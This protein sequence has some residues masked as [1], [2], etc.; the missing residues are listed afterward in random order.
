LESQALDTRDAVILSGFSFEE[1]ID[2]ESF[3]IY[4][5]NFLNRKPE[6]PFNECD[7]REFLRQIG[8]WAKERSSGNEGVTLAGILMFGKFRSILD[9]LPNYIVD[10]QERAGTETR[11]IDRVTTDGSWS[12]NLHDFYRIVT[13]KLFTDLKIPFQLEG[14]QRIE[15]TPVHEAVREAFVNTLIHADYSGSYSILVVKCPDLFGFRNPGLMRVPKYEALRGGTSDCRNRNL[16][17]MFQFL[18]RGEQAGSGVPMIYQN[19]AKQHWREPTFEERLKSNQT[20]MVLKMISLFPESVI[21]E[22]TE[23]YGENF[24]GLSRFE[25]LILITAGT[26]EFVNHRRMKELVKEHSHDISLSLHTLVEKGF[27]QREGSS[28]GTFYYL[29]GH[30]PMQDEMFGVPVRNPELQAGSSEHLTRS[31]EHFTTT[32]EHWATLL[33]LAEPVRNSQKSPKELGM[34]WG[35]GN[36]RAL[37]ANNVEMGRINFQK[38][39]YLGSL[40]LYKKWMNNG[41]TSKGDITMTTEAPLENVAQIPDN[42]KYILSQ[43]VILLKMVPEVALSDFFAQ[44]FQGEQFQTELIKQSTGTTVLGIQQKKLVKISL[45]LPPLPEQ[46]RIASVLS[47][48]DECIKKTEALITKLKQ[49][50]AGLMQDLLTRG[51]DSEGRIRDESTHEF[52]DTEVGRVPVE[53]DVKTIEQICS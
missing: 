9:A 36:I 39:T 16:Q 52:K 8:G 34:D 24:T 47:T 17:K 43:R 7:D 11:W 13:K 50:K 31:P 45:P 20:V 27:L 37:S 22:L 42:S 26:D 12:G 30:H 46:H 53:W 32:S 48:L 23:M 6:H 2:K 19:W 4:R 33:T 35:N 28:T 15:D 29:T 40:K 14:D 5:Q 51:I 18:E 25:Q 49:V 1:D 21:Q 38:E 3:R 44:Y 10:Y 41:E